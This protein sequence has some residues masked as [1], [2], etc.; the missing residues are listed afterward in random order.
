MSG[1]NRNNPQCTI[2]ITKL[3]MQGVA[4]VAGAKP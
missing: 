3:M 2:T 1:V 4:E